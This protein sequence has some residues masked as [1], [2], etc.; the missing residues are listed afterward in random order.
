M[1]DTETPIQVMIVNDDLNMRQLWQDRLSTLADINCIAVAVDGAEAIQKASETH[2]DIIIMDIRMP[3]IDGLEATRQILSQQPDML[4]IIY[5]VHENLRAEAH[6]A[7]AIEYVHL[8]IEVSQMVDTI[9]RVY[10]EFRG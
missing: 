3:G 5:S 1:T 8:P 6:A 7:G 10:R 4:I 2:P 9:R